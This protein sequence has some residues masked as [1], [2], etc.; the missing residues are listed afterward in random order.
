MGS[1]SVLH[2]CNCGFLSDIDLMKNTWVVLLS[3]AV[4]KGTVLVRQIS[5]GHGYPGLALSFGQ[6]VTRF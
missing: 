4:S 3:F 2:Q 6:A 1:Q 5:A